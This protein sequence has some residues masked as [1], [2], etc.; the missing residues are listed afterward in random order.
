MVDAIFLPEREKCIYTKSYCEENVW[1]LCEH[2]QL[3]G[4][5]SK[6]QHCYAV[7]ISNEKKA[8]PIWKQKAST[9][10]QVPIIWDY[11][12][13]FLYE[14]ETVTLV[15][16]IDSVLSFPCSFDTYIREALPQDDLLKPE[17]RRYFRV[18]CANTFLANFASD[19][20]H[21]LKDNTDWMMP[22]PSY[23]CI[24]TL[25]SSNNLQE[26]IS[27]KTSS[28]TRGEVMAWTAFISRFAHPD[29]ICGSCKTP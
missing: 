25:E 29:R 27:M 11:H 17:F 16:D 19:R 6:L 14:G 26:F 8:V 15:Y 2:V 7:F 13:I 24:R 9:D 22:P 18:V 5:P 3:S 10:A 23:P 12:V 28:A 1:K 21:M 4:H 20:K